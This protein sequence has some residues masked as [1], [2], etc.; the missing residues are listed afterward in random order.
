M[1]EAH[2]WLRSLMPDALRQLEEAKALSL[3]EYAATHVPSPSRPSPLQSGEDLLELAVNTCQ[4]LHS[5]ALAQALRQELSTC[6]H[7]LTA[8]HH[9]V[10]FHPEFFQGNLLFAM[11]CRHAVPLFSCGAV[12]GNN[13]AYP[14]GILLGSHPHACSNADFLRLPL[15]PGRHRHTLVS[16]QPSFA[17]SSVRDALTA[18]ARQLSPARHAALSRL[19]Q[20]TYLA[21]QVLARPNFREQASCINNLLWEAVL[22]KSCHI[23]PLVTLDMQYL[24]GKL[25]MADLR[26]DNTLVSLLLLQ[27]ELT[28]AVWHALNG[29]RACW[30]GTTQALQHGT[31]L[32][33]GVDAK[34]RALALMPTEDFRGLVAAGHAGWQLALTPEAIGAALNEERILPSLFL[35]FVTVTAARGLHCAGGIFQTS[36][37]PRMMRGLED[38]LKSCGEDSLAR[39][40]HA[41]F[42]SCPVCTGLLPLR[43]VCGH[44][45]G[46]SRVGRAAGAADIWLAGGLTDTLWQQ[47]RQTRIAQALAVSLPYHYDD[48][49]GSAAQPSLQQE[50]L[51]EASAASP[52]PT[53]APIPEEDTRA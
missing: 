13:T 14:R 27:P 11:S 3:A 6:F 25:I 8:N 22:H 50:L 45:T 23:P 17:A 40:M 41:T 30:S 52:L 18:L 36:Y 32:F 12:P 9:G 44:D 16:V 47:L 43:L 5:A 2:Q 53:L 19:V 42:E 4:R 38:A 21:P 35:Y 20:L 7:A 46:K 29:Q 31:F 37:L 48:L 33:W 49:A 39:R 24:C 28:A 26:Q 10:D 34:G 15:L 1:R 51:R